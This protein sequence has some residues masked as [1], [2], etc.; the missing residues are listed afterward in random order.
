M[1]YSDQSQLALVCFRKPFFTGHLKAPGFRNIRFWKNQQVE[2][3][4]TLNFWAFIY[5]SDFDNLILEIETITEYSWRLKIVVLIK[6]IYLLHNNLIGISLM[7]LT[8]TFV[9]R[10]VE[11]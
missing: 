9:A 2:L 7:P 5:S 4:L 6:R 1:V 11:V 10:A 8:L 3:S